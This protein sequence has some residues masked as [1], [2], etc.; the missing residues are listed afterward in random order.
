MNFLA[1]IYLSGDREKILVGNF[2]GDFIK[3]KAHEAYDP[4][5]QKGVLLHRE[6]DRFTD[7]HEVV[8]QSKERLRPTYHHYA[9]V[10]AD[11]FY[12]HF[13]ASLWDNYHPE[14]LETFTEKFY[15]TMS[16]Y[17][18]VVPKEAAHIFTFM[19]KDNWLYQYKFTAGVHRALSGMAR[20]TPYE[21]KME[22]AA[23]DLE[24]DYE[25]YKE[26]F[27]TFFPDLEKHVKTYL[28]NL[29]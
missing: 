1:H 22:Q 23:Q 9:P 10:I 16:K 15:R 24:Q 12:D 27:V 14:E 3:G 19:Q 7:V 17:L 11:I 6:I 2:A 5:I 20:R 29:I 21:S 26:E 13:L 28:E 25:A 8:L 18:S 4:E